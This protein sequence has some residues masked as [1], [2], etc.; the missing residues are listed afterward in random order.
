MRDL[1][2]LLGSALP[3]TA[4]VGSGRETETKVRVESIDLDRSAAHHLNVGLPLG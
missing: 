1:Y 4:G 3:A 2:L